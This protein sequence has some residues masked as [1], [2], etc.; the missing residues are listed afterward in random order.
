MEGHKEIQ[1]TLGFE[2]LVEPG[3]M[4]GHDSISYRSGTC[5]LDLEGARA[6]Q[7]A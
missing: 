4:I 7:Q 3:P 6:M 1:S 5:E 2:Q